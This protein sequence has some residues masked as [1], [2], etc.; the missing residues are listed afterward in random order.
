MPPD[1]CSLSYRWWPEPTPGPL[2]NPSPGCSA[3]RVPQAQEAAPHSIITAGKTDEK[4]RTAQTPINVALGYVHVSCGLTDTPRGTKKSTRRPYIHVGDVC[5]S[6]TSTLPFCPRVSA[7]SP[8]LPPRPILVPRPQSAS[9]Y[10]IFHPNYRA[11]TKP[12]SLSLTPCL[13]TTSSANYTTADWLRLVISHLSGRHSRPTTTQTPMR[14]RGKPKLRG[15]IAPLSAFTKRSDCWVW[16][17]G[18][19]TIRNKP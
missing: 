6:P 17:Y 7:A 5:A 19:A 12:L 10:P 18:P 13:P 16:A 11:L 14:F 3:I 2:S 8:P 9:I 15:C 1:V 4:T